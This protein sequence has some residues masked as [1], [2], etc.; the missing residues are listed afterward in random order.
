MAYLESSPPSASQ[1]DADRSFSSG[2]TQS[3]KRSNAGSVLL[4]D[5][6]RERKTQNEQVAD[7]TR[8]KATAQNG[9]PQDVRPPSKRRESHGGDSTQ[10][11]GSRTNGSSPS[12]GAKQMGLREM[13]EVRTV[14]SQCSFWLIT[15]SSFLRSRKRISILNWSYSIV[16]RELKSSKQNLHM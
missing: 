7:H 16:A 12:G 14:P 9:E 6:L 15:F 5:L 1:Y 8:T 3:P 13:E 10:R 2:S 11:A 4:H